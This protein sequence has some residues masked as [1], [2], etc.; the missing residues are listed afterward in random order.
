MKKK[1]F[2][3]LQL[4]VCNI[5]YSQTFTTVISGSSTSPTGRAPQGSMRYIRNLWLITA[6]EMAAAGYTSGSVF[7]GLGFNYSVAQNVATTGS[8]T[9]YMEN[10]AD[11]TNLK[12]NDWPTAIATMTTVSNSNITI[13]ATVGT[14]DIAFTGGTVFTYTGGALYIAFDYQNQTGTLATTNNTAMCNTA[15]AG[16]LRGVTSTV[17]FPPTTL[18]SSSFR[19][20]TRIGVQSLGITE[21]EK[22]NILVYP[23]PASNFVTISGDNKTIEKITVVSTDGKKVFGQD[24][25]NKNTFELNTANYQTGMYVITIETIDGEIVRRKIIKQ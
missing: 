13:P 18:A 25:V 9:V 8:F 24:K 17:N 5:I 14:Y 2:I 20:E 10:T 19:P 7:N 15:L 23:N 12:S 16:G 11:A 4:I 3:I 22:T 6:A 21:F 1:L